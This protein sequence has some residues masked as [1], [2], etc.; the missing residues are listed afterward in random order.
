MTVQIERPRTER[1]GRSLV[2]IGK[3]VE[4]RSSMLTLYSQLARSK[5]FTNNPEVGP[6]LEEFCE[7]LIDYAANAHFQLY[8][9]F[10]ENN[11]RRKEIMDVAE[12]VYPRIIEM[13]NVILDFNDKYDCRDQCKHLES[14]EHDLSMLGEYLADRIELEDSLIV[15]FGY[16][17]SR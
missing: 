1:R 3:L 6:L 2:M 14:L 7:S 12:R 16:D 8:R 9:Y 13:T 10:A 17:L 4:V 15:A 11:E 5:P